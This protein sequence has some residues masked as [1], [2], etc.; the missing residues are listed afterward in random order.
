MIHAVVS[1]AALLVA[2]LAVV[3]GLLV[4]LSTR[5]LRAAVRVLL[6]L[7]LAAGLLNLAGAT[8]WTSVGTAAVIIAIRKIVS[9]G[10]TSTSIGVASSTVLLTVQ[11]RSW[12]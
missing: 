10:L 4:L 11:R 9:Y 3:V 1:E 12:D 2:G 6:D 8:S 5:E 7:L